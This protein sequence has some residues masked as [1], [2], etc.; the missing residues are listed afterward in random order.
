M[1]MVN[2]LLFDFGESRPSICF[3][4][5]AGRLDVVLSILLFAIAVGIE[6]EGRRDSTRAFASLTNR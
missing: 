3:P 2:I 6:T 1:E 5:I 4:F